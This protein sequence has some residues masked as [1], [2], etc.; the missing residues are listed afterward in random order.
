MQNFPFFD[1]YFGF[2][3]G[4]SGWNLDIIYVLHVLTFLFNFL[5]FCSLCQ[6]CTKVALDFVSPEN[7]SECTR[8]TQEFR[9]LP[10]FHKSKQDILEVLA[11][12]LLRSVTLHVL[13]LQGRSQNLLQYL[14]QYG[15]FVIM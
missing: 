13:M 7:V 5:T 9:L 4:R 14:I 11:T 8:L 3:A 10:Q 15:N 2:H 6:S 1:R 12:F